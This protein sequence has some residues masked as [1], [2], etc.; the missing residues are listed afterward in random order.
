MFRSAAPR[1]RIGSGSSTSPPS[2]RKWVLASGA[3][4]RVLWHTNPPNW[5]K[6]VHSYLGTRRVHACVYSLGRL[7]TCIVCVCVRARV[8]YV[9]VHVLSVYAHV[10]SL[11][12]TST[13]MV[14]RIHA[15]LTHVPTHMYTPAHVYIRTILHTNV[16][17]TD[18]AYTYVHARS[19]APP[20]K[21]NVATG[22]ERLVKRAEVRLA[23]AWGRWLCC[24]LYTSPSPRD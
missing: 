15:L 4:V 6:R 20:W 24:L 17:R 1:R 19:L 3:R 12:Q 9:C 11:H 23:C 18:I 14:S 16:L 7:C 13:H 22:Y 5:L 2:S 8:H 21:V 10:H